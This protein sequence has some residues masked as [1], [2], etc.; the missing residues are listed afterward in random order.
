MNSII[1]KI[2]SNYLFRVMAA[3]FGVYIFDKI[4][5]ATDYVIGRAGF[6]YVKTEENAQTILD[7]FN[8]HDLYVGDAVYRY[9]GQVE[10]GPVAGYDQQFG[11]LADDL[12]VSTEDVV[13]GNR[14]DYDDLQE[15]DK[16]YNGQAAELTV[17]QTALPTEG[18]VNL[19]GFTDPLHV[20]TGTQY[21]N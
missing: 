14:R 10:A 1:Q 5:A 12:T 7:F 9:I 21:G 11:L 13:Y 19:T 17:T 3:W 15:G 8:T 18:Y 4:K 6:V 2:F 16:V 20:I